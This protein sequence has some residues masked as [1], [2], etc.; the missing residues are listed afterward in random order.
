MERD[1]ESKDKVCRKCGT[2]SGPNIGECPECKG[3]DF[4]SLTEE[5]TRDMKLRII[6]RRQLPTGS[7]GQVKTN[8]FVT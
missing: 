1:L 5:E 4:R 7:I 3:E 2:I 8:I 6:Y